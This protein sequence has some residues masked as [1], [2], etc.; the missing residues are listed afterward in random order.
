[1]A[2]FYVEFLGKDWDIP[3][4]PNEPVLING[5][6]LIGGLKHYSQNLSDYVEEGIDYYEVSVVVSDRRIKYETLNSKAI[7]YLDT[8]ECDYFLYVKYEIFFD[9]EYVK[10]HSDKF[11]SNRR[12]DY[13]L[14]RAGNDKSEIHSWLTNHFDSKVKYVK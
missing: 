6:K 7:R 10:A 1:M 2:K 13:F 5:K 8:H 12:T 4:S 3:E 9:K 14:I 11:S